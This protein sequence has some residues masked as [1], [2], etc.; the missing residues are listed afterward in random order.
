MANDLNDPKKVN[1]LLEALILASSRKLEVKVLND[2][3]LTLMIDDIPYE[4]PVDFD[5]HT[6]LWYLEG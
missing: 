3:T 2:S 4:F 5:P 6:N 1:D